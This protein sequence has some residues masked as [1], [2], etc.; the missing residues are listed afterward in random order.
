MSFETE[1]FKEMQLWD[2]VTRLKHLEGD[3]L[4]GIIISGCKRMQAAADKVA[5]DAVNPYEIIYINNTDWED[6]RAM[7]RAQRGPLF[8]PYFYDQNSGAQGMAASF[9]SPLS[10]LAA[11]GRQ[12]IGA[13]L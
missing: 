7:H 2:I 13:W 5:D 1:S 10:S 8:D 9:G 4:Q 12:G 3:D 11:M 6:L